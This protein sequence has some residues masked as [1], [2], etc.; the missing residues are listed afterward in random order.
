MTGTFGGALEAR[1][2]PAGDGFLHSESVGELEKEN[3][4]LVIKRVHI[5]Y[6]LN[7]EAG[8]YAEKQAAIQ[9]AFDLHPDSCPVYRSI[10]TSIDI[11]KEL[12]VVE[13]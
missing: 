7:V 2:I 5:V 12:D 11:T 4:T 8:L 1:G 13:T 10:Y 3:G 6:R 9:R